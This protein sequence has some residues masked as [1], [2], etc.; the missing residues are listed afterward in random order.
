MIRTERLRLIP[1]RRDHYTAMR[2]GDEA[3]G[4]A[5]G[6]TVAEGWVGLED[7]R[8]VII[9]ADSFLDE[10]PGAADWWMYL[11]V[12]EADAALIGVGG[13]KGEPADGVVEFGYALAPA[14][15]GRGLALEAARALR[16]HALTRA[17]VH[18]V[19][20]HTLPEENASTRILRGLGL[21]KREPLSDPDDGE[22]WRW[23]LERHDR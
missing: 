20:A 4:R 12:L 16:D 13:F 19:Q 14:Y 10:H 11:F 5:L 3:L 21:E 7:H 18:T 23:S 6:L 2:E 15:R 8:D 1:A 17:D 22:I 9:N